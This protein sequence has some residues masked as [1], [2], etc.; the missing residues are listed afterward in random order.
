MIE[1]VEKKS[2]F[3]DGL[4]EF[5]VFHVGFGIL[6]FLSNF[7]ICTNSPIKF[8]LQNAKWMADVCNWTVKL[9]MDKSDNS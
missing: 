8:S 4:R 1:F 5:Q 6:M 9:V 2:I 3:E 7:V